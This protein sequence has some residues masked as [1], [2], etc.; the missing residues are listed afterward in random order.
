MQQCSLPSPVLVRHPHHR[1]SLTMNKKLLC[2]VCLL[3]TTTLHLRAD[4]IPF[5]RVKGEMTEPYLVLRL[6][7]AQDAQAHTEHKLTLSD[8]QHAKLKKRC[9]RFPKT[10][11]QVFS[12]RYNDCTCL[13]GYPYVILLPGGHEAALTKSQLK[14]VEAYG[15]RDRAALFHT[16]LQSPPPKP[17]SWLARCWSWLVGFP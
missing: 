6:S 9:P 11:P 17:R 4:G 5:D 7:D 16:A 1:V 8:K 10:I 14:G 2:F 15:V 12:H 3:S 13:T